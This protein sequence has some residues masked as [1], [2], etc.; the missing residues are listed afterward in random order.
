MNLPGTER[1]S[2]ILLVEDEK[3]IAFLFKYNITKAGYDCQVGSNGIEGLELAKTLQPD[4]II[5]DIMMPEMDGFEFRK[6]VLEDPEIRSIPFVFLTAKGEEED[7]LKGYDFEI[8]DYI[9]KTASTKVIIAKINSILNSLQKERVR[10]AT[11]LNKAADTM[12]SALVPENSPEFPGFSLRHWN[13]PFHNIP[14]GD[15]IDYI[16]IGDNHLAVI[17]GDVMGKKWGAWYFA[18]AY[19]GYVRSAVRMALGNTEKLLPSEI[20]KAVNE[21]VYHDER[22]AEVFVTLS[23]IILDKKEHKVLYSGAGDLPLL[24]KSASIEKILSKGALLGLDSRCEFEDIVIDLKK[25]ELIIALT[26]G[27]IE[28]RGTD[29]KELFGLERLIKLIDGSQPNE[30]IIEVVRNKFMEFTG[31]NF[32]DDVT[33]LVIQ[34]LQT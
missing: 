25:D 22:I 20:L 11:E 27:I 3:N 2:R 12:V 14:G 26:D 15:F 16:E 23:V 21:S 31:G 29:K 19:A 8:E 5:S 9:I 30:D 6:H 1:K 18:V 28:S 7:V 13:V 10:A 34:G 24:H 4:L 33:L 17:L 32:E